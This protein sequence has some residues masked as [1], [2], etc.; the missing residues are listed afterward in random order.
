MSHP[1]KFTDKFIPIFANLLRGKNV[2]L[3]PFAGTGKIGMIRNFGF[4][5]RI[6]CNEIEEGFKEDY[7]VEWHFQDSENLNF[8]EDQSV[9]AICTSPTYGNRMADTYTDKTKRITYTACLGKKLKSGNTG[10]MQFGMK[11]KEKHFKIYKELYR[12]LK[13]GGTFILNISNHIRG[14]S[15]V[16]V[17]KWH[18]ETLVSIGFKINEI[19]QIETQRMGFGKNGGKRCKCEFIIILTKE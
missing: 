7:D 15:E 2:V 18:L 17:T 3:D 10:S 16:D 13:T 12:V 8:L 14:G 9:D 19:K 4:E 5:G 1:A 6:I 11:Y